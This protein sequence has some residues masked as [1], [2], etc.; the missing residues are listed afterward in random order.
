MTDHAAFTHVQRPLSSFRGREVGN[1]PDLAGKEVQKVGAKAVHDQFSTLA[2]LNSEGVYRRR[3]AEAGF[4]G[5]RDVGG[6]VRRVRGVQQTLREWS[7]DKATAKGKGKERSEVFR[8]ELD[9][10]VEG[11]VE[12]LREKGCFGGSGGSGWCGEGAWDGRRCD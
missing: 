7:W 3:C 6:L 10:D 12:W 5:M 4:G 1:S 8:E 9:E 2:I 11:A